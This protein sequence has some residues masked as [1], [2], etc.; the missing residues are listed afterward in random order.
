MNTYSATIE[1]SQVMILPDHLCSCRHERSKLFIIHS[2]T[3]RALF[4]AHSTG[5]A[6]QIVTSQV[7]MWNSNTGE[8]KPQP[9]VRFYS[10]CLLDKLHRY[11]ECF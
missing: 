2:F 3:L 4:S 1:A 6:D 8:A 5:A 10:A 9:K 7:K 11:C